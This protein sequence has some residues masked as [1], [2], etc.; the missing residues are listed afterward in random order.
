MFEPVSAADRKLKLEPQ[1]AKSITDKML[2]MRLNARVEYP[3]PMTSMSN[4]EQ[5]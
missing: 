1:R 4:D 3:E 5:R 2:L